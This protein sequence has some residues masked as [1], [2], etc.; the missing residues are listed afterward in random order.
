MGPKRKVQPGTIAAPRRKSNR[1]ISRLSSTDT[2]Y[3]DANTSI[4]PDDSQT[5][6]VQQQDEEIGSSRKSLSRRTSGGAGMRVMYPFGGGP[7]PTSRQQKHEQRS[8]DVAVSFP[9]GSGVA[10]EVNRCQSSESIM[11]RTLTEASSSSDGYQISTVS[12]GK[13]PDSHCQ[14]PS[15]QV[16]IS[17]EVKH[18]SPSSNQS[19][20]TTPPSAASA[21]TCTSTSGN[22]GNKTVDT[23][24]AL[25]DKKSEIT[26]VVEPTSNQSSIQSSIP[27]PE[28]MQSDFHFFAKEK[29]SSLFELS[30]EECQYLMHKNSLWTKA[31]AKKDLSESES[32]T[33]VTMSNVNERLLR[34]WMEL[35]KTQREEYQIK[36]KNDRLRYMSS[37]AIQSKHCATTTVRSRR[38]LSGSSS[39]CT[40]TSKVRTPSSIKSPLGSS[41]RSIDTAL[42]SVPS[43]NLQPMQINPF[44]PGYPSTSQNGAMPSAAH[45]SMMGSPAQLF[46]G[47]PPGFY[48]V[49]M[50]HPFSP[51]FPMPFTS[52]SQNIA[53][54]VPSTSTSQES[55]MVR[56]SKD[57]QEEGSRIET[58]TSAD[59]EDK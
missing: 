38:D 41:K 15:S 1:Q 48:P 19:N 56:L 21:S 4:E 5:V 54:L 36:E 32:S 57:M 49:P 43:T 6:H 22:G 40:P 59:D 58:K 45:A 29:Y 39:V 55:S 42:K 25:T 52:P 20:V 35:T 23:S 9:I 17:S 28:P 31:G 26:R 14:T 51:S 12:D 7:S 46:P 30:K 37:E 10:E 13:V 50:M 24:T 3:D 8:D 44:Y 34:N 11:N 18:E 33:F 47:Y 2:D 53:S 16:K 27:Q